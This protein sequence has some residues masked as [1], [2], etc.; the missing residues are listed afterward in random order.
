MEKL[1][2][3]PDTPDH[4][5]ILGLEWTLH[6]MLM[7]LSQGNPAGLGMMRVHLSNALPAARTLRM[8][9]SLEHADW[10]LERVQ[11][12]LRQADQDKS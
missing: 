3:R 9:G 7:M 5:A 11:V 1:P 2:S 12:A 10:M 6:V 8:A 4:E